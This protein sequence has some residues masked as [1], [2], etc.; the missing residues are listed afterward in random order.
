VRLGQFV[1]D[2]APLRASAGFRLVFAAQTVTM[3]G[4]GLTSVAVFLQVY[5]LTGSSLQVGLVGLVFGLSVFL[6]LLVGGILADRMDRKKI[7][8]STRVL[9]AVVIAGL[10]VNAAVPD[11]QWWLVYVAAVLTGGLV[12][13]GGPALMA[14]TPVLVGPG[15]LAAAGALI[16]VT[17][18]LGA[19]VG[20]ALAG[21]IA[22]GPGLAVCYAAR[23]TTPRRSCAGRCC[24]TTRPIG[25]RAGSAACGWPRPRPAR[26]WETRKPA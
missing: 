19:M 3:L 23:A 17:T 22:A 25:C 15:L 13:L 20:P 8:V 10:A 9:C 14:I 21:L 12:G 18:Q 16:T 6:G 24:S 1:I 2:I 4:S 7:I 5:Q 11:P 26:R